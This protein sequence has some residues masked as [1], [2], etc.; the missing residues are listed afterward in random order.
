MRLSL[1]A[2]QAIATLL[3]AAAIVCLAGAAPAYSMPG[4][5]DDAGVRV[6][7][8]RSPRRIISLTPGITEML[9]SLGLGPRIVGDTTFCNYPPKAKSI[10][11]VGNLTTNYEMV[12]GLKPD[13]V[14]AD[15]IANRASLPRLRA[16]RVPL[17]TIRPHNIADIETDIKKIGAV[18]G[19]G[20][21]AE[22]VIMDME[23]KLAAAAILYKNHNKKKV[24]AI[25]GVNPLYAAGG[26]TFI[27][28]VIKRAGAVNIASTAKGY[29]SFS[30][31]YLFSLKPDNILAN[32]FDANELLADRQLRL[33]PAIA[34]HG[35]TGMGGD[36]SMRP[37]PRLAD[38]V[39]LLAKS[40]Y[41]S[42]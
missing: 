27:D 6:T 2:K 1:I 10:A 15:G 9:F 17:F 8:S 38:G 20:K 40:L 30:K 32:P 3:L 21:Q 22:H 41:G 34:N 24:I 4:V 31:E 26:G 16:L 25:V 13:L 36:I 42:H 39:L 5:V 12:I 11:K 35:I 28:D 18:T 23:R 33:L 37:G 14:I 29:A 19:T 7:L